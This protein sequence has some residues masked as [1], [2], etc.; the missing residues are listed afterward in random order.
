MDLKE[1]NGHP[2]LSMSEMSF[3]M[4][5]KARVNQLIVESNHERVQQNIGNRSDLI[6]DLIMLRQLKTKSLVYQT[7]I[8]QSCLGTEQLTV[9]TSAVYE[10]C[11]V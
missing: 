3:Y 11:E 7:I 5:D 4:Y 8:A 1:T 6:R 10:Q 9:D 2:T